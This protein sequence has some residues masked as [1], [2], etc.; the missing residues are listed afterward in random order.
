MK[1]IITSASQVDHNGV[2]V[3]AFDVIHGG[4]V[5]LSHTLSADVDAVQGAIINFLTA[6]KVK[7]LSENKLTAGQEIEV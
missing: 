5:V 1:A 4:E 6:Y 2:Q 7:A 3:V